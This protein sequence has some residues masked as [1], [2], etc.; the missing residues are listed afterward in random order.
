MSKH[1]ISC[2]SKP[3]FQLNYYILQLKWGHLNNLFKGTKQTSSIV[4]V[5]SSKS[6]FLPASFSVHGKDALHVFISSFYHKGE[7]ELSTCVVISECQDNS[8]AQIFYH[9]KYLQKTYL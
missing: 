8:H 6:L 1:I 9:K 2:N 3:I 4:K 5:P 7:K